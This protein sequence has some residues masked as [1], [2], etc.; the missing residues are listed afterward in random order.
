MHPEK[1]IELN[2]QSIVEHGPDYLLFQTSLLDGRLV[3]SNPQRSAG[4]A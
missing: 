2:R 3:T 1:L 4:I